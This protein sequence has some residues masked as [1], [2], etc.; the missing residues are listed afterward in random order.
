MHCSSCG[1][2]VTAEESFCSSC[3]KK[4]KVD[5]PDVKPP[6]PKK[7][8]IWTYIIT[9]V[10][11]FWLFGKCASIISTPSSYKTPETPPTT[12]TWHYKEDKDAMTGGTTKMAFIQSS[13][14]V[15]FNFPYQ[16]KQRMSLLLRKKKSTDAVIS[17]VKGQFMC[18]VTED[19]YVNI[20]FDDGKPAKYQVGL[21][22][23][24]STTVLFIQ[25][26]SRLITNLLKAKRVRIESTFYQEGNVVFEF[27]TQ[28]LKWK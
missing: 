25:N 26:T 21:P 18:H 24:H 20:R 28:D 22:A 16:G 3:G 11:F 7:T 10:L 12:T 1:K 19:C 2:A 5:S 6:L 27:N 23:D 17:I 8:S 13:N 9:L 15:E 14:E 4:L